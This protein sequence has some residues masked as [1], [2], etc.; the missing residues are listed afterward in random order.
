VRALVAQTDV[1]EDR[2][3]DVPQT[4]PQAIETFFHHTTPQLFTGSLITLAALRC[5]SGSPL[6]LDDVLVAPAVFA[7][8]VSHTML[9]SSV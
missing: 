1:Q 6:T 2:W 9:E 7:I 5:A 4:M 3:P 8:W